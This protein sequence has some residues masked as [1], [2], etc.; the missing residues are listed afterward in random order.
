MRALVVVDMQNDFV[1]GSLGSKEAQSI[2]PN[3][4]AKIKDY[5]LM[6]C[7]IL[8]TKDTHGSNY[9]STEEGKNLP[10]KHCIEYTDGWD[11]IK[12]IKHHSGNMNTIC[13]GTFG[14]VKLAEW[15]QKEPYNE[16]ELI[17][18][19]TDICVVSNA[20]LIKAFNPNAKIYVDTSCCA[21]TSPEAH[22]A[23]IRTMESCQIHILNKGK[24]PWR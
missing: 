22:D 1:T 12:E 14:S 15:F 10:V 13:K 8:F 21:G 9:L 19:C 24:E 18:L 2:V 17:G 16:I 4:V 20:L 3:V 6:D 7:D 23:A 5:K 11:L